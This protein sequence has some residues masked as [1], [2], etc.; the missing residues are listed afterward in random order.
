MMEDDDEITRFFQFNKDKTSVTLII[1]TAKPMTFDEYL[2]I[3]NDFVHEMDVDATDLFQDNS[4][5]VGMN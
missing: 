5:L 2:T 4:F 1:S 3:L